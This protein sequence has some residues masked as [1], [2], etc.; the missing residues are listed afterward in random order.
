M[1]F[2]PAL[3]AFFLALG[4]LAL[5][6]T[7]NFGSISPEDRVS[8]TAEQ[9]LPG[10]MPP[11]EASSRRKPVKKDLD[12]ISFVGDDEGLIEGLER[13]VSAI[14]R[15]KQ[16]IKSKGLGQAVRDERLFG[17]VFDPAQIKLTLPMAVFDQGQLV[18]AKPSG[19]FKDGKW[20]GITRFFRLEDGSLVE[21]VETD[22]ASVRGRLYMVPE[23]INTE[24]HGKPATAAVLKNASGREIRQ[25]VWVHGP[26]SFEFRLL[27]PSRSTKSTSLPDNN[28][29][30]NA[31][32]MARSLTH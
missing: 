20:T 27:P 13:T 11:I 1:K 23:S 19:T 28:G 18:G 6:Q 14:G 7:P 4:N 25:V 29:S 12:G 21:I 26:K 8:I 15:V 22:L 5:A 3:P 9:D 31:I 10:G 32:E 17:L 30:H 16:Q 2:K 24:I